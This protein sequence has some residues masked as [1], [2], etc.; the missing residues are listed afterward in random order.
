MS[1]F[2]DCVDV[3]AMLCP[4]EVVAGSVLL[5]AG[6]PG[7]GCG[8]EP[9]GFMV[10]ICDTPPVVTVNATRLPSA[11]WTAIATRAELEVLRPTRR[12]LRW[13]GQPVPLQEGNGWLDVYR[14]VTSEVDLSRDLAALN[15]VTTRP[16]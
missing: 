13:M 6:C 16:G 2:P 12:V 7:M 14:D 3:K 1:L 5:A 4:S 8:S 11:E 15:I 9:S 10:Q